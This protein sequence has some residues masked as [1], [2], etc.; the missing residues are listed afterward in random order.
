M[1]TYKNIMP[2]LKSSSVN[3]PPDSDVIVDITFD[4]E[5]EVIAAPTFQ[6]VI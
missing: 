6:S 3:V 5:P 2:I 1:A 4:P